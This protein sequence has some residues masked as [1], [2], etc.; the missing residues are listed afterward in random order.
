MAR[1]KKVL[2]D[3]VLN[4]DKLS[5]Y[6][7][8]LPT[9]EET[10]DFFECSQRSVEREIRDKFNLSFVEFRQQ[11]GVHTRMGIKRKMIEKALSGDNT[12]LIWLSK[13]MLG[14]ADKVESTNKIDLQGEVKG[15]NEDCKE[16]YEEAVNVRARELAKQMSGAIQ[17]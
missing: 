17:K 3:V 2:K 5:E 9:L 12:M 8:L 10:A 14:M 4:F 15:I 1:P 6:M 13:N 11:K 16:R 7:R